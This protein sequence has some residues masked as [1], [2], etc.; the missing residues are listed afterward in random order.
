[1]NFRN[2]LYKISYYLRDSYGFDNFSKCLFILGFI[3]SISKYTII[4]GY[5][6]LIYGTWRILSKNKYKR[7]RELL[8]FENCFFTIK[9][10]FYRCKSSIIGFR[11]Y[12]IFK[13]PKCSQ[14]LRVPRKKGK[15]VITCKKC[16]NEFRGKA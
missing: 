8:A 9:R 16:G 4:A 7:Q 15:V 12:K 2:Y 5:A 11:Q 6:I 14:K 1:M 13:C 10:S 3:L